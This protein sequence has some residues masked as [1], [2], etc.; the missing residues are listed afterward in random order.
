[1]D[2]YRRA[3]AALCLGDSTFSQMCT[4]A[5]LR[6]PAAERTIAHDS[7]AGTLAHHRYQGDLN[8]TADPQG[9]ITGTVKIDAPN[10]EQIHGF[11]DE[12]EQRLYFQRPVQNAGGKPQNYTGFLFEAGSPLFQDGTYGPPANP[13]FRMLSGSFDSYDIGGSGARPLFGWIAR[14]NI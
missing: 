12:A 7:T 8:L 2:M 9:N 4:G 13:T 3:P 6:G 11:W 10:V 5:R 1:M 14:Q